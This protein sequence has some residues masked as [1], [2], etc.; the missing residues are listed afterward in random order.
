LCYRQINFLLEFFIANF[1]KKKDMIENIEEIRKKSQEYDALERSYQEG[2]ARYKNDEFESDEEMVAF[3][4]ELAQKGHAGAQYW[5]GEVYWDFSDDDEGRS[6]EECNRCKEVSQEWIY[7]AIEQGNADAMWLLGYWYE[8]GEIVEQDYEKTLYWYRKSVEHG[9]VE[10]LYNLGCLYEGKAYIEGE[11][12][13]PDYKKA[14][15]CYIRMF[16]QENAL[17]SGVIGP[18]SYNLGMLYV[19]GRGVEADGNKAFYYF[20][21]SAENDD[22]N[23]CCALGLC[24]EKGKFI[25]KDKKKAVEYYQKALARFNGTGIPPCEAT[26]GLDRIKF[27]PFAKLVGF[28]RFYTATGITEERQAFALMK[29]KDLFSED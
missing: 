14:A 4:T 13:K 20:Q 3:F 29:G 7:K 16:E 26:I 27:G 11:Q 25:E 5:L 8:M 1:E 28:L 15:E 12:I 18:A 19:K 17:E 10:G 21:K 6:E 9:C 24:Y 22:F 2:M 23:G